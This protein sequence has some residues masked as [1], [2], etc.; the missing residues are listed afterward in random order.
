MGETTRTVTVNIAVL[1][2]LVCRRGVIVDGQRESVG[3]DLLGG[4]LALRWARQMLVT[5]WAAVACLQN[6]GRH[7]GWLSAGTAVVLRVIEI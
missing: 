5:R 7:C 4:E 3:N 2:I 6:V 1:R